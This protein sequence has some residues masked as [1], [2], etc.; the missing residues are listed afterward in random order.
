MRLK[1]PGEL[2]K[3]IDA[4]GSL[5]RELDECLNGLQPNS[6]VVRESWLKWWA[7]ADMK[8]RELFA[9]DDLLVPLARTATEIRNLDIPAPAYEAPT[10]SF[11][12]RERDVWVERLEAAV[13]RMIQLR[14]FTMRPG[15]VAVLDT[16]AFHEFERFW[17][18]DWP[19]VTQ[20]DPPHASMPGLPIRLMVPLVVVEELD[21]QK[22]HQNGKVRQAAR[23]ILKHLRDLERVSTDS[24]A[25]VL[26]LNDRVTIEILLDT[27]SHIR[28]PVNDA[29]IIDR[30]VYLR[31]LFP[32][33]I[34]VILVSGD[35]SMEFRAEGAGLETKHVSRAVNG[36]D[37]KQE[38]D[39]QH[40]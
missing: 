11:I 20:A 4:V 27:P 19:D 17:V 39:Q 23:D 38:E 24:F 25:D 7:G 37:N 18:A 14:N 9:D 22:R 21:A 35:V 12:I 1:T 13:R 5:A 10:L 34:R 31:S 40:A 33:S 8:L 15:R 6:Q 26:R 16:S 36:D 2:Q 3:A 29:E 30:A 32:M 28:L